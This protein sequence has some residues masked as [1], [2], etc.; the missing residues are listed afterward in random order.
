[1]GFR[2]A[3]VGQVPWLRAEGAANNQT[4]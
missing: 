1:L 4:F 2:A 3:A